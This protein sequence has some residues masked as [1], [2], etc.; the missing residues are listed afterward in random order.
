MQFFVGLALLAVAVPLIWQLIRK[1]ML[2][3]LRNKLVLTYLLIGLAPGGSCS[4][5]SYRWWLTSL[6]GQFSIHLAD[7][8][9]Q[10][11]LGQMS[12]E[13]EHRAERIT[14]DLLQRQSAGAGDASTNVIAES[15]RSIALELPRMRLHR[16]M[17]AFL[18]GVPVKFDSGPRGKTP[19]GLPPW[20]TELTGD[21]YSGMV[22]D[23]K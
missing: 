3:S 6:L 23:G 8:R 20:A 12:V 16:E 21:H 17:Q 18:N 10:A 7:S 2:W 15:E 22:L 4:S 14:Q 1:H 13:N 11:E 19:F 9:L 5:R